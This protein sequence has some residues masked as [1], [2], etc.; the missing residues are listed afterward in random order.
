MKKSIVIFCVV[1]MAFS[2]GTVAYAGGEPNDDMDDATYLGNGNPIRQYGVVSSV[3]TE[4]WWY[5]Y[6]DESSPYELHLIWTSN[7]EFDADLYLY[8]EEGQ[9]LVKVPQ[10]FDGWCRIKDYYLRKSKK[11][12]FRVKYNSGCLTHSPYCLLIEQAEK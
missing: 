3:D 5:F 1:C 6:V 4:D 10:I 12:Y 9:L 7:D 11:Y 2:V 8:N